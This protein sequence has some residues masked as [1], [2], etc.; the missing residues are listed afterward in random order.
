MQAV[1]KTR[2][3]DEHDESPRRLNNQEE[4]VRANLEAFVEASGYTPTQV[5]DMAGVPQANVS[6]YLAGKSAIP[7]DALPAFA[8][9]LGRKSID[10]FY[11][12]APPR[13]R[14]KEELARDEPIIGKPRPG[15]DPTDEDFAD[16]NA[17]I[18][19]VAGRAGKKRK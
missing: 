1:T 12:T 3:K 16:I 9:A 7:S 4:R 14:T 2:E 17:T 13:Q 8:R 10:D 19:K 6:R 18:T 5:A 15:Y 11:S